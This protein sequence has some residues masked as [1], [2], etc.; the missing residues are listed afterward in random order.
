MQLIVQVLS[1]LT[2]YLLI[3]IFK[4]KTEHNYK[5]DL[6]CPC[7]KMHKAYLIVGIILSAIMSV[8]SITEFANDELL[9]FVFFILALFSSLLIFAYFGF[10]IV[11]DEEKIV[12]RY[13]FEAPKTIYYKDITE[14]RV[15]LDLVIRTKDRKLTVSNYMTNMP[16][17][18]IKMMPYLPKKKKVK[19]VPK[20]KSFFDAVERPMDYVIVFIVVEVVMTLVS[21][22]LLISPRSDTQVRIGIG[23]VWFLLLGFFFLCIHSAKRAHSSAFWKKIANIC[24]KNGVLRDD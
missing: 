14:V 24:F 1:L 7:I 15:G 13:F 2:I 3:A 8:L 10:R 16:A 9:A 20:V 19:E 6:D 4:Y 11:F 21:V 12:Y 18:L 5:F 22:M 23:I 17:L